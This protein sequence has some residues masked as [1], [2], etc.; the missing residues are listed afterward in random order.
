MNKKFVKIGDCYFDV[1]HIIAF[2]PTYATKDGRVD[3]NLIMVYLATG[4]IISV[5]CEDADGNWGR[6]IYDNYVATLVDA[7]TFGKSNLICEIEKNT[8]DGTLIV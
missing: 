2:K 4:E 7:C 8:D 1:N 3:I 5:P 6:A